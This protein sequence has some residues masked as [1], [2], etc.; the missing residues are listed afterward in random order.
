MRSVD[1]EL[2]A[3]RRENE[4]LRLI[5]ARDRRLLDIVLE[6]SPHGVIMSDPQGRLIL[7]NEAAEQIWAGSATAENVKEWSQYQAFH[8]DG[9]PFEGHDWAMARCLE[10][11]EVVGPE[12]FHIRRF[13]GTDGWLLGSSAPLVEDDLLL[14]AVAVFADITEIKRGEAANQRRA[15]EINDDVVQSVSAARMALELD[16]LDDVREALTTALVAS[17]RVVN[18]L[19]AGEDEETALWP[20]GLRRRDQAARE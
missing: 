1:P 4:R 20:G 5:G 6:Q 15:L 19:L 13:D 16:R 2:E 17:R 11:R 14:G 8:P 9:R 12:E 7:Q 18:D 3:L 10:S